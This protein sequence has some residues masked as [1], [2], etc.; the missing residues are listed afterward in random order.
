MY[1]ALRRTTG[2]LVLALFLPAVAHAE[3]VEEI[4]ALVDGDILTKSEYEQEEQALIQEIYRRYAG[5]ELDRA[6]ATVRGTL[7]IDLIDRKIL[8]HRAG[9]MFDT[10]RMGEAFVNIF[11]AQLDIIGSAQAEKSLCEALDLH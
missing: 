5:D 1:R 11:R 4:V 8:V 3:I 2:V 7:L 9:R 10:E 6:V